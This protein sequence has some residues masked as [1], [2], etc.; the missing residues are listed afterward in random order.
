MSHRGENTNYKNLLLRMIYILLI[1]FSGQGCFLSFQLFLACISICNAD[2]RYSNEYI[3]KG[4]ETE[5]MQ[6]LSGQEG[7]TIE[8]LISYLEPLI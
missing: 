1:I 6:R 5:C 8:M 3:V 4:M 7:L 2:G